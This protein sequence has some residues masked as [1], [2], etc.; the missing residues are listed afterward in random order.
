[1]AE[2][3]DE[4]AV[5]LHPAT[6][7]AL[8]E[9]RREREA[10]ATAAKGEAEDAGASLL[11]SEDFGMSQFWYSPE[12]SQFLAEE[13]RWCHAQVGRG[14]VAFL[15]SP[16]AYKAYR[17]SLAQQRDAGA[18]A[19]AGAGVGAAA[20]PAAAPHP[21]AA[22]VL[23]FD[24]RFAVFQPHF[25]HYDYNHPLRG[26]PPELL[27]ACSVLVL[28]PPFLNHECLAGFAAT[29]EA[30]RLPA[31]QGGARLLLASGAVQLQSAAQLLQLR[32]TRR[33]IVHAGGRLL[34]PFAL[35]TNYEHPETLGGW[36]VEAERAAGVG[37]G[38]S[39]G[40][41]RAEKAE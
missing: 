24:P 27:G 25:V 22:Y 23:E 18:G 14:Q 40:S 36:D 19:G 35:F 1:M 20:A 28:D 4:G 12:T 31:A 39:D 32:P 13:A 8:A 2:A 16:S 11:L 9:F 30:L 21:P 7:A 3:E 34:N 17:S 37:Q 10:Q 33:A 26:L 41:G 5:T 38:G 15:A 29:V 6:L